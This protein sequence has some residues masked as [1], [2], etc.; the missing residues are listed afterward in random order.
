MGGCAA[1]GVVAG[2]QCGIGGDLFALVC[3]PGAEPL[4]LN[5]SGRAGA[6]AT[7]EFL[8]A[9]GHQR[10][11]VKG[12][13]SVVTPGCVAG[14]AAILERFGTHR[15]AD[16]LQ[17]AIGL[18]EDGFALE[19]ALASGI[20][21]A[22]PILNDAAKAVFAHADARLRQPDLAAT[23]RRIAGEGPRVMYEG[24][25]GQAIGRFLES[26]G[27]HHTPADL[28]GY[29]PQWVTPARV[30]FRGFEV[31]APPPNSQALLHLLALAILEP[32]DLAADAV[33]TAHRQIQAI[34]FA[35]E[36]TQRDIADPDFHTPPLPLR[37]LAAEGRSRLGAHPLPAAAGDTVYLCAADG[38]GLVV[39]MIQS[40]REGFGS[41]LMVP[42]VG[43]TLNNRGRDFTLEAG[44]PNQI[45]PG[46]RPRHTLSPALVLRDGRPVAAYGTR[47]GDGQPYTMLQLGSN[48]LALGMGPQ[49]ALDAPR[50]TVEPPA[51]G[52]SAG[53][54]ALEGRFPPGIAPGLRALGHDTSAIDDF[55]P[56]CG[57]ASMVQFDGADA[58]EA[59]ADPRGEGLA[60]A[61]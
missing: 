43:V 7:P 3:R 36:R 60:L 12:P 49:A 42:G 37:E 1:L 13:L 26:E 20:E 58:W 35:L 19:P 23:L 11:P 29:A 30:A 18:A 51:R 56:A 40:L 32:L 57:V 46:K 10:M 54:I 48:L 6:N 41:G 24:E 34:G 5:A 28:A 45:A 25:L 39:S 17:P 44:H 47:G 16:V 4:V 31:C 59:A 27:G 8:A 38:E 50:W 61:C 53:R 55:D 9:A 2:N 15:L 33:E 22:M 52:P 14:W 21:A